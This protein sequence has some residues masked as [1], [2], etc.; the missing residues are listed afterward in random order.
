LITTALAT[1]VVHGCTLKYIANAKV[2]HNDI[3]LK[4]RRNSLLGIEDTQPLLNQ[5]RLRELERLRS[6]VPEKIVEEK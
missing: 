6:L 1:M 4:K 3:G 2:S 5:H